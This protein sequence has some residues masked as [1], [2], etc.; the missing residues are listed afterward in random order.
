M[1]GKTKQVAFQAYNAVK[2][3]KEFSKLPEYIKALETAKNPADAQAALQGITGLASAIV[4]LLPLPPD[5]KM[6]ANL[7][8]AVA[9]ILLASNPFT[10]ALAVLGLALGVAKAFSSCKRKGKGKGK[11]KSKPGQKKDNAGG[12]DKPSEQPGQS[13]QQGQQ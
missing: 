11:G 8:L 2:I 7:A 5:V 13:S 10:A 12:G 6:A 4:N 9:S 3:I 1:D